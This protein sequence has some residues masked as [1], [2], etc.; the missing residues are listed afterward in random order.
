[1][2]RAFGPT[3]IVVLAACAVV[4]GFACSSDDSATGAG[5]PE[6]SGAGGATEDAAQ[7]GVVYDG[8]GGAAGHGGGSGKGGSSQ[9]GSAGTGGSSQGGSAG[10][11]GSTQGGS[12][13]NGGSFQGG[14][15]GTGGSTGQGGSQNDSGSDVDLTDGGGSAGAPADATTE[16]PPPSGILC[17]RNYPLYY[18][19]SGNICCWGDGANIGTCKVPYFSCPS[20]WGRITCTGKVDCGPGEVCCAVAWVADNQLVGTGCATACT[21]PTEPKYYSYETCSWAYPMGECPP[22]KTCYGGDRPYGRC[23]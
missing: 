6:D 21:P 8:A 16:Q 11:G 17:S 18:C 5:L 15:A 20:G 7:D 12:A 13:G 2:N 3:A 19:T 9:G 14:S 1:M 23:M 4:P 22:G 10:T